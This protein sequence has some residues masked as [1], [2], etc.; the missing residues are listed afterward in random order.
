MAFNGCFPAKGKGPGK[1]G[2]LPVSVP[3]QIAAPT[4][5]AA[6]PRPQVPKGAAPGRAAMLGAGAGRV[7]GVPVQASAGKGAKGRFVQQ[8]QQPQQQQFQQ[9]QQQADQLLN[10]CVEG[11]NYLFESVLDLS[12]PVADLQQAWQQVLQLRAH[13]SQLGPTQA[14]ESMVAEDS[15]DWK[16]MLN[17]LYQV[18]QGRPLTKDEIHYDSQEAQGGGYVATVT[19]EG[20]YAGPAYA[21]EP[22]PSKKLALQSAAQSAVYQ[23]FP[24]A[25][26]EAMHVSHASEPMVGKKR[27]HVEQAPINKQAKDGNDGPKQTLH[28]KLQLLLGRTPKKGEM[29]FETRA[30]ENPAEGAYVAA[31]TIPEID[32]ETVFYGLPS[33]S[34]K[35]A[36]ASA[37]ESALEALWPQIQAA[38]QEHRA[39]KAQNR[40]LKQKVAKEAA[41][42]ES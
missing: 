34:K 4:A 39:Q 30:H 5:K 20:F 2:M 12:V 14:A 35:L 27:K 40:A 7:A 17:K 29:V 19:A 31:I 22:Q 33:Q 36:E 9:A 23:E 15:T 21:G 10:S 37:C 38:E 32:P 11:M 42:P 13:M 1:G 8:P 25:V 24:E 16:T 28:H 26:E 3:V 6:L 41:I 18:R